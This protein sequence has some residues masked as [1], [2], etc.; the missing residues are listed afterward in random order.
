MGRGTWKNSG[1]KPWDLE[2]AISK[3]R[4]SITARHNYLIKNS[5]KNIHKLHSS[6]VNGNSTTSA[7]ALK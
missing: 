5:Q 6:L 1:H 3:I 7:R 4:D 2:E